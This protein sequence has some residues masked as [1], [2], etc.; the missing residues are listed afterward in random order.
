MIF[1]LSIN[2]YTNYGENLY[3]LGSIPELGGND[4]SKAIQLELS[5]NFF[6][7][8]EI[9]VHSGINERFVSYK[10]FVKLADGSFLHE[11]GE[12]RRLALNTNTKT[13]FLNDEWQGN[14]P[15]APFLTS[16]FANI[17][18]GHES[19]SATYTHLFSKELIIRVTSPNV[20][21]NSSIHICGNI[22]ELGGWSPE[23]APMMTPLYGSKWE[24][25]LSAQKLKGN[26]EYKFIKKNNTTGG[27]EWEPGENRVI[28]FP[29]IKLH[30]TISFEYSFT[31]FVIDTPRFIG[32]AIPIFSLR[33]K[34]SCG[35]GDFSD[36]KLFSD[37]AASVGQKI[38]QILPIN[39][40]TSNGGWGDS[41]PYGGIS[42][43][44]LHPIYINLAS[45]GVFTNKAT[46]TEFEKERKKLNS[47][48]SLDY[49]AV[50]TFK[51]KYISILFDIYSADTFAE[52]DF[53]SFY[54]LNKTW[55]LPYSA[56]CT[57]RDKFQTTD[58][59]KW[60]EYS[61]YSP[62]FLDIINAKGS[63]TYHLMSRHLFI[64]YHLHKQLSE[65]VNY[66]HNLGV[67][68]KGDIPIGITP[69]SVEA[70]TEPDI[71]NLYS[72][73][74]A[75]PDAFSAEGQNWGFPTY[76]WSAMAENNYGWWRK[77]LTKMTDYFDAYRIDHILGF[78]RI[79]EIPISQVR[80]L[81]GY[82]S[83]ALPYTLEE[84]RGFGFYFNYFRHATPY[85]RY[86]MLEEM[87]G[88]DTQNVI[89]T[90]LTRVEGELFTLKPEFDTQRKIE[91]YFKGEDSSIKENLF[92]LVSEVLFIEDTREGGKFHPRI[93]SQFSCSYKDLSD[94]EKR[95]YNALYDHFFYK[96]HNE[97]WKAQAIKKL[98]ELISATNMLTCAEDL[99]MIPDSVPETLRELRILSLE[100]QRMPKD[101][102]LRFAN[103][104][105][106]PYLSVCST[107]T[108]DT[109]TIRGWWEE[110]REETQWFFNNILGEGGEAPTKCEPWICEKIITQHLNTNSMI[111]IIPLQDWLSIDGEIR[112]KDPHSERINIPADP[113]HKWRYRMHLTIED[114]IEKSRFNHK[115][116]DLINNSY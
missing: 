89:D 42:V 56:F 57:L 116:I 20:E 12:E 33:S 64:Q 82:F 39:D 51:N 100:I 11:A 8:K 43:M 72:Q 86:Y 78:F 25:H 62:K 32:S 85:I 34:K 26:I 35:I 29:E 7:K 70:W 54:K 50:M 14:T 67:I 103:P 105:H 90:F 63:E 21:K 96:K 81:M 59:S 41:Y 4:I 106:Y 111:T 75:P 66:A 74:G 5:D 58:F 68:I 49:E 101:T 71:F 22:A 109:S 52:P 113:K 46:A 10:Y 31:R 93:S 79:W 87:F 24:I 97:F 40:T 61:L 38:I 83:P 13:L 53:Y 92:K 48:P 23:K 107:G 16:P 76:N 18:F 84:L 55:L 15:S 104:A 99:G 45:I 17:F 91:N 28:S 47:L 44:A 95:S 88:T 108:H 9:K 65:A 73:A 1:R 6:W 37:W 2:F 77:R 102:N 94:S 3:V 19:K 69:H 98:P 115:L 114:L 60:G 30:E 27:I 112:A 80:G 110:N 36:I